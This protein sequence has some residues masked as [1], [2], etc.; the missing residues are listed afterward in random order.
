MQE[1]QPKQWT[2]ISRVE[3]VDDSNVNRAL[4]TLYKNLVEPLANIENMIA[5]IS[6]AR[7]TQEECGT[8]ITYSRPQTAA[9]ALR[10][11]P[12]NFIILTIFM[13]IIYGTIGNWIIENY[14]TPKILDP[15]LDPPMPEIFVI[16]AI[17]SLVITLAVEFLVISSDVADQNKS[18]KEAYDKATDII[19]QLEPDLK[20][21]MLNIKDAIQFVPPQYRFSEALH[22]FVDSYI[23][24]RV[25]NLK[26]A[27]NAYE[28]H[29]FRCQT[30]EIQQQLK[31]QERKNGELLADI[32][33]QQLVTLQQ[34]DSI[35]SDIW[36]SSAL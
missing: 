10:K 18:R 21:Q 9:R 34:L 17:I 8:V 19:A 7:K 31:E 13:I 6:T 22:Y 4:F 29:Y 28:T 32:Y 16:F 14:N 15:I 26:E 35:R 25:D 27:V 12:R 2:S 36:L 24:S 20:Q 23:N 3:S 5:A 33:Y 30:L 1:I 11:T